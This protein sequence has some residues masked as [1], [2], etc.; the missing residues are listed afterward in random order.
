M[1]LKEIREIEDKLRVITAGVWWLDPF[2]GEIRT[3]TG[4]VTYNSKDEGQAIADL[5]LM[6]ESP[7]IIKR[8][9]LEVESQGRD[10]E[11][12]KTQS[13]RALSDSR[14]MKLDTIKGCIRL[15]R[16]IYLP[17]RA[18]RDII[19]QAKSL[20]EEFKKKDLSEMI[21][22]Q[23]DVLVFDTEPPQVP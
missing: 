18:A 16:T 11:Y 9:L 1:N 21:D 4:I 15:L 14:S 8:L 19:Q 13:Q 12:W 2:S 5:K 17:T 6:S 22:R 20:L 7:E 3:D 23:D 10:I